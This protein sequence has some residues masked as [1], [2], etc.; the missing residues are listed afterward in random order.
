[1]NFDSFMKL[2]RD[3]P[4]VE[5]ESVLEGFSSRSALEVQMS[6]WAKLGKLIP[7]RRGFYILSEPYR[8][9]EPSEFFLASVLRQP[10]YISLEKALEYH[11]LIPEAV[12]VYTSVTPKRPMRYEAKL[13]IFDYKHLQPSLFWGYEAVTMKANQTGFIASPEKALL[14]L[15]Y[16]KRIKVSQ[17]YLESLRLQNLEKLNSG[18]L[19]ECARQFKSPRMLQAAEMIQEY[20]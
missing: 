10:S 2:V 16:L 9:I 5:T 20:L 18:K 12:S 6:R 11:D 4:V 14:D 13:G 8:K 7:L 19:R 15:L 1:M 3:W 17:D